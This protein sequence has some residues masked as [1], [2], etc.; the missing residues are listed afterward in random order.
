MSTKPDRTGVIHAIADCS[1]CGAHYDSRNAI[2][3]AAQHAHRTGHTVTAEQAVSMT[4]N[5]SS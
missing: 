3:L 2:G 1:T 4:W 5:P